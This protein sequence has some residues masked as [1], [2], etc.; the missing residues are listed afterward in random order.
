MAVNIELTDD[1]VFNKDGH[2]DFGFG[3]SGAREV[4]RVGSDII[5]DDG[6]SSGGSGATNTLVQRDA[7]MWGHSPAEWAENE[8]VLFAFLFEHIETHPVVFQHFLVEEFAMLVI[9]S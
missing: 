5:D 4:S 1:F 6:L 2:N 8:N 9:S 3:F 7:S